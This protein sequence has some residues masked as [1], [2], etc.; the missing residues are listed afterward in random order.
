MNGEPKK[1]SPVPSKLRIENSIKE[2]EV[3][4]SVPRLIQI[5][6]IARNG[7]KNPY[8]LKVTRKERLTLS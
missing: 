3:D 5:L 8:F 2:I 4:L 6:G 7:K 1:S